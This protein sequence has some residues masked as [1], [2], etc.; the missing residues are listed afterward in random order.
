MTRQ[1]PQQ[2]RTFPAALRAQPRRWA[3]W[4]GR[5]AT[6]GPPTAA[7]TAKLSRH[8]RSSRREKLG[9]DQEET[10]APPL[11]PPPRPGAQTTG[12]SAV[13]EPGHRQRARRQSRNVHSPGQRR[14]RPRNHG[15]PALRGALCCYSRGAQ[16]TARPPRPRPFPPLR[17]WAPPPAVANARDRRAGR[18]RGGAAG[19]SRAAPSRP[20]PPPRSL[21]PPPRNRSRR[22]A[23]GA[24]GSVPLGEMAYLERRAACES[25]LPWQRRG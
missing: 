19:R 15:D 20:V 7:E 8:R 14:S 21:A 16:L 22:G 13:R 12:H 6:A 25:A 3:G 5:D 24:G 17:Q 2:L 4:G 23:A 1:R 18:R 10:G 9:W 11:I